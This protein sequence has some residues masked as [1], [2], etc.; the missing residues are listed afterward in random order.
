[1][2]SGEHVELELRYLLSFLSNHGVLRTTTGI[3]ELM[4]DGLLAN[5]GIGIV[6]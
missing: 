6:F 3:D 2:W 1:M 5:I 4:V